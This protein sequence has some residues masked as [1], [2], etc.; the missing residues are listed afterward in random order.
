MSCPCP[1]SSLPSTHTHTHTHTHII[2]HTSWL[3]GKNFACVDHHERL[4]HMFITAGVYVGALLLVAEFPRCLNGVLRDREATFS[5]IYLSFLCKR[6]NLTK[7]R[8]I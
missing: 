6:E 2:I 7:G 4:S 3:S 8:Q 1:N 5:S